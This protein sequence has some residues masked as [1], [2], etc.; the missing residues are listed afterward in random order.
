MSSVVAFFEFLYLIVQYSLFSCTSNVLSFCC[1]IPSR[2]VYAD[3]CLQ[4]HAHLC[5]H[6]ITHTHTCKRTHTCIDTHI[7]THTRMRTHTHTHTHTLQDISMVYVY[8]IFLGC[9]H[10]PLQRPLTS[11]TFCLMHSP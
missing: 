9:H 2:S 5:T 4:S 3:I 6:I 11:S 1:R 10:Y 8:Y 7:C